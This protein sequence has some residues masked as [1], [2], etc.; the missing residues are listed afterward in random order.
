MHRIAFLLIL[1]CA[2]ALCSVKTKLYNQPEHC[3]TT[4]R[5]APGR[6]LTSRGLIEDP[7]VN[8]IMRNAVAAQMSHLHISEAGKIADVEI[9]F[10]GGASAGLQID[11]LTAG[12]M[13]VWNT[14]GPPPMSARTYPKSNLLIAVVEPKANRTIWAA[15]CTD[16]FGDP[17]RLEERI[18]KAVTEAFAKFPKKFACGG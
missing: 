3:F 12:N 1:V 15:R 16:K 8:G 14:G 13:A 9:R 10:M 4:Y 5:L 7:T 11:D 18:N 6:V 2:A 17:A